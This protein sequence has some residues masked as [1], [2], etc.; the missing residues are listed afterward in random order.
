MSDI[1]F[2]VPRKQGEFVLVEK[3][4]RFIGSV[5]KISSEEEGKALLEMTRKQYHDAS[6]HCWCYRMDEML[7]RYSDDGE[8]QGTAGLPM[9]RVFEMEK[10]REVCCV[11]TRY[12]G[13]TELGTG[14]L[15]RAYSQCAKGALDSAGLSYY[16]ILR[17]ISVILSYGL[18]ETVEK[19]VAIH[20]GV[21]LHKEFGAD[22][23]LM[24]HLPLHQCGVFLEDLNNQT[25]GQV[26]AE[27][28][29]EVRALVPLEEEL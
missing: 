29:E 19:V 12:F 20:G 14:G 7:Q 28:L 18:L 24:A 23:E 13:G 8:P 6:H 11:V 26:L 4:S 15:A 22:V 17:E 16:E 5:W 10:V 9:L 2:F 1:A 21:V 3:K 27:E 25:C